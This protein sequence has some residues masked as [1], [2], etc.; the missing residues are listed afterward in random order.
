MKRF[1]YSVVAVVVALHLSGCE[2]PVQ[3]VQ[4]VEP[5]KAEQKKA[6]EKKIR[7]MVLT[8]DQHF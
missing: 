1:I 6:T 5:T 7:E 3:Q 2:K 4:Y 8:K